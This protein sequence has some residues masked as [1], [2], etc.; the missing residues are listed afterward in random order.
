MLPNCGRAAVNTAM[1]GTW[2]G[3]QVTVSQ[4]TAKA[5]AEAHLQQEAA[6]GLPV[7]AVHV[8][9]REERRALNTEFIM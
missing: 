9:L 5:P 8:P 3:L 6:E 2:A 7:A 4:V 1:Y